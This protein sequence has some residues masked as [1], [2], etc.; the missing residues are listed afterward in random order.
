MNECKRLCE[1]NEEKIPSVFDFDSKT[2]QFEIQ[3]FESNS[4]RDRFFPSMPRIW[5]DGIFDYDIEKWTDSV[6]KP[7]P[8]DSW[9][10]F[11]LY[12]KACSRV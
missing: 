7:I 11:T 3:N 8:D 12:R 4:P 6:G 5:T 9:E 1:N 10:N 2:I